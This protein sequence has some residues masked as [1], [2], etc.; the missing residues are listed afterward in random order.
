VARHQHMWNKEFGKGCLAVPCVLVG[1]FKKKHGGSSKASAAFGGAPVVASST[2]TGNPSLKFAFLV[3]C[4][5][6]FGGLAATYTNYF[7]AVT[8]TKQSHS[9]IL[10]MSG[11]LL[12]KSV[13]PVLQSKIAQS[14]GKPSRASKIAQV[15][16]A[17][18][19]AADSRVAAV[20]TVFQDGKDIKFLSDV[21]DSGSKLAKPGDI[22]ATPTAELL[23]SFKSGSAIFTPNT[24]ADRWGSVVTSYTP[25]KSSAGK[26]IA[27]LGI[28][29]RSS[30]FERDIAVVNTGLRN[31]L[32]VSFG[33]AI[34]LALVSAIW[35]ARFSRSTAFLRG[36]V[37][38]KSVRLS[39]TESE[40]IHAVKESEE[41]NESLVQTLWSS[42]CIIWNG[43]AQLAS[44]GLSWIGELKYE[45]SFQW[46][47]QELAL[48]RTFDDIWDS[49]RHPE[50]HA[51]WNRV[52]S[53]S[54]RTGVESVT[55]EYRV[56]LPNGEIRWFTEKI[57]FSKDHD[58]VV[59]VGGF[60]QDISESRAKSEEVARLAFFDTVTGLINR[61]R[62]HDVIN[63]Y[64]IDKPRM[65]VIGV[66]ISNFR[67]INES[68]GAEIGDLVLQTVGSVLS[69]GVGSSG[70][71]GRLAGDDF[72]IIV[73]D[74][75]AISMLV[76][77]IDDLCQKPTIIDGV[78][79]GKVCRV[80]YVTADAGD[81]AVGLIRKANLALENARKNQSQHP[82]VYKPEM[83]F[84]AKMRVELETSMR[85]ALADHE[86][87]LMFQPIYDNQTEKLV[88]AEA[89]LRW[90]SSRF[91]AVSPG[92]FI[93]IAEESDFINELGNFV[94]DETAKAIAKLGTVILHPDFAISLNL[95]L[96]QLKS[97]NTLNV[98]NTA[99]DRWG[100][101]PKNMIIEVTESSIMHDAGD[102]MSKLDLLQDQGFSLAID[103]FGTGYSSLATL[104]SLPFNC[105][106]I[107]KRFVDGIGNDPKQEAVL[108]TIIRLARA[109]NLKIVAEGIEHRNQFEFLR[110]QG[111][112]YSQG[113]YF[114][115]PLPFEDIYAL[116]VSQANMDS[117]QNAA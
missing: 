62:I 10:R 92:T 108:A 49:L 29:L 91:G 39:R 16:L 100:I 8:R 78:E 68:W 31:G 101:K 37:V 5:A 65:G 32:I 52:V 26:L 116:A 48:G 94:I 19:A 117:Q 77:K 89:L 88:K 13:D 85:Q 2:S 58:G 90:N 4:V 23:R 57:S 114:A 30:P 99:L 12:S 47:K 42:N 6:I 9:D 93:P 74:E 36:E 34:L 27:I 98:F 43:T 81:N 40:L 115:K 86:F 73:P 61:T 106:K 111:V 35:S 79:I 103:D 102:C 25:I 59:N 50:D 1:M 18:V 83:S 53:A 71:V 82:V 17:K 69:D 97:T 110:E 87:Y 56:V 45:P 72:V 20:Y 41:A 22:Y 44:A 104:A 96:Q 51:T 28:G 38:E 46:L 66:E 76:S 24:S 80:G 33:A 15:Q 14:I 63:E 7:Q 55:Q 105:L 60:V 64:I 67:N 54:I 70:I 109:L 75:Y 84:R 107:D 21:V 112:E 11:R 95:S 113:Y 3:F